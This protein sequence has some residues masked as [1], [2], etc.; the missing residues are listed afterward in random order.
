[1][2]EIIKINE[3]IPV[4]DVEIEGNHNF[5]ANGLCA[6]NCE[7]LQPS[8]SLDGFN[9]ITQ[10]HNDVAPEIGVCI[11]GS[12]NAGYAKI[13]DIPKASNFLVRFLDAMIDESDYGMQEIEYAA[14]NRRGLG[15]GISNLF[16]ALAKSKLFYNT[17]EAREFV[18]DFME[19]L[20]W[21]LHK[22]SIELASER[23][24]CNL[25]SDTVYSD[26]QFPHERFENPEFKPKLDWEYLRNGLQN[27]GIRNSSLMA[28]APAGN[29]AEVSNS[30]NGIEP[31]REL[32]TIKTDKSY[33][34]KK[35]VPYY[36]SGK[37]YYTTAWS[38]EFNNTDYLKLVS[39]IQHWTDQAISLN[40][41]TNTL[42][43]NSGNS[44]VAIG[45]LIELL[46]DSFNLGIK[47]WYYQNFRTT[48]NDEEPQIGCESGG[49]SV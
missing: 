20:S 23:G 28:I 42:G 34:F 27:F 12:V 15:I 17:A 22:T 38:P 32:V 30:T 43:G 7:I 35:L 49:C 39:C 44:K 14:V 41:Y 11:L 31:P 46:V 18:N 10:K 13:D 16:G 4:Y 33:T 21:N 37:N 45:E 6:H 9:H 29:S 36:K 47:T 1:M 5:F 26:M 3:K 25:F 24:A 19:S 2:L 40:L 48:E 8:H